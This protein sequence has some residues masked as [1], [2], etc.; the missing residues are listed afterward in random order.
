MGQRDT[1]LAQRHE[2]VI[3][4]TIDQEQEIV[5]GTPELG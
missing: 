2:Y 3:A 4:H 1:L 5:P